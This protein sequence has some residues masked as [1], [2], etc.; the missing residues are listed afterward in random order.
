MANVCIQKKK[1]RQSNDLLRSAHRR[2]FVAP[3]SL[4][5]RMPW[6][7]NEG[8][9]QTVNRTRHGWKL[10]TLLIHITKNDYNEVNSPHNERID[11]ANV[12]WIW[13]SVFIFALRDR[14]TWKPLNRIP[15]RK[16]L[17]Y[18]NKCTCQALTAAFP[19]IWN[20]PQTKRFIFIFPVGF[21]RTGASLF[22]TVT[23]QMIST[24]K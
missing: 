17:F 8:A 12:S 19:V 4:L 1:L 15:P 23:I 11:F 9:V 6:A 5:S 2:V 13:V 16:K 21:H 24:T 7:G 14:N 18:L 22:R 20:V 10:P 3:P